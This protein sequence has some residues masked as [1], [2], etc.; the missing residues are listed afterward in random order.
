MTGVI[1]KVSV[2]KGFANKNQSINYIEAANSDLP[3]LELRFGYFCPFHYAT[4]KCLSKV[5]DLNP[6]CICKFANSSY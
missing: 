6:P 2:L 4:V 3:L 5:N 1:V